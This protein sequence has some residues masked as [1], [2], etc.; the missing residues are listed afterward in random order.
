MLKSLWT[1][2]QLIRHVVEDSATIAQPQDSD[3]SV[4]G[5]SHYSIESSVSIKL[6]RHYLLVAKSAVGISLYRLTYLY[7]LIISRSLQ[8]LPTDGSRG[9]FKWNKKNPN[10]TISMVALNIQHS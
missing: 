3:F 2:L 4:V 8:T 1:Q 10:S 6:Y 7:R 9:S 5:I